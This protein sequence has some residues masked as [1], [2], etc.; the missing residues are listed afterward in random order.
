MRYTFSCHRKIYWND[1][2][3]WKNKGPIKDPLH[4]YVVWINKGVILKRRRRTLTLGMTIGMWKK[5]RGPTITERSRKNKNLKESTLQGTQGKMRIKGY[6]GHHLFSHRLQER[7]HCFPWA[8]QSPIFV[9]Q[10]L[11][12]QYFTLKWIIF[13][14]ECYFIRLSIWGLFKARF[15][16]GKPDTKNQFH[17]SL[18]NKGKFQTVS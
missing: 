15:S 5:K 16:N 2:N 12:Y 7:V 8:S 17:K 6:W 4:I 14:S 13:K 10:L 9:H 18:Q 3:K 1:G 11:L